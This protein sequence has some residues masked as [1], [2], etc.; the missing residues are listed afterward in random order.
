MPVSIF[1]HAA[2]LDKCKSRLLQYIDY[3]SNAG[4]LEKVDNIFICFIGEGDIPINNNDLPVNNNNKFKLIK[5]SDKLQDYELPT[6]Q[7]LYEYCKNNNDSNV[8]YLHTKNVGKEIN[9]CIEDQIEY[10]LHFLI[11]KWENCFEKL[12]EFDSCGVDLREEPTLHYS[13]NFWWAT[14]SYIATLPSPNEFNN[15]EKYPNTLNS[16]RHNQEF[17]ICY[18]KFKKHCSLWD[19]GINCYERHIHRYSKELYVNS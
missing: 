8:L 19:C 11:T 16:I 4:L 6:L 12:I 10:M 17:W 3:I 5:L 2:I 13:G 18:D 9:L 14:S 15:L 1:I 7:F